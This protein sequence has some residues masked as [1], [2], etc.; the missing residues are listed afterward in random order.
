MS[1]PVSTLTAEGLAEIR[2]NLPDPSADLSRRERDAHALLAHVDH[3]T[4]G[5]L[6]LHVRHESIQCGVTADV[7]HRHSS[8]RRSGRPLLRR[9]LVCTEPD[10]HEGP[11]R[12]A[13]CCYNFE[14][15]T[16]DASVVITGRRPLAKRDHSSCAHCHTSWP[17]ETVAL[18]TAP[19]EGERDV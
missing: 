11:H 15:F 2:A 3:L 13:I 17:C 5:I 6:D 14:A 7:P 12:D 10:G 16:D 18:I 8:E 4:K 19:T 1:Q 9:D